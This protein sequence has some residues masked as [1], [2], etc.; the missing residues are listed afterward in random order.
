MSSYEGLCP[1]CQQ[2]EC[3]N[4]CMKVEAAKGRAAENLQR[5]AD[6]EA[7]AER[8][9]EALRNLLD[10]LEGVG[11]YIP[12]EDSGQWA[13]TEGLSFTQAEAALHLHQ[14]NNNNTERT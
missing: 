11:I 7:H 3:D 14:P 8:L 1:D 2:V 13:G 12:G 10:Q 4:A 6:A 5:A 9:A